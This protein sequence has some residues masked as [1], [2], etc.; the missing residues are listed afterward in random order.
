MTQSHSFYLTSPQWEKIE[1][2][3]QN[4]KS[5]LESHEKHVVEA[6]VMVATELLENTI[7]YGD[8]SSGGSVAELRLEVNGKQVCVQ[9]S[10]QVRA[11]EDLSRLQKIID[12]LHR[13]SD[14]INLYMERLQQILDDPED[15]MSSLGLYRM[16]YEGGCIMSMEKN[17]REIRLTACRPFEQHTKG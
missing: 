15:K 14:P 5:A 9:V 2:V 10:S 13:A 1:E 3:C 7:K 16:A 6:I 12:R 8:H 11:D 17:G 4:V